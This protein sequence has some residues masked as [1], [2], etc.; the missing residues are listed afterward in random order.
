MRVTVIISFLVLLLYSY[1]SYKVENE[2]VTINYVTTYIDELV[3]KD[4]IGDNP[5]VICNDKVFG[6][7]KTIGRNQIN[8][9]Q[10]KKYNLNYLKKILFFTNIGLDKKLEVEF[11]FFER[12]LFLL[13]NTSSNL[14]CYESEY[15]QL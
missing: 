6:E 10:I 4:I 11:S 15:R 2:D 5:L 12:Y 14:L 9:E 8:L 1:K 13:W 3:K 7:L